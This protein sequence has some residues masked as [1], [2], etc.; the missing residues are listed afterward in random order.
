MSIFKKPRHSGNIVSGRRPPHGKIVGVSTK[1]N[2]GYA[3][4]IVNR[5]SSTTEQ[6]AFDTD[7]FGLNAASY[8]RPKLTRRQ[9]EFDLSTVIMVTGTSLGTLFIAALLCAASA[10]MIYDIFPPLRWVLFPALL[11]VFCAFCCTR[12]AIRRCKALNTGIAVK[13]SS[14]VI[15]TLICGGAFYA[16][17]VAFGFMSLIS[18]SDYYLDYLPFELQELVF[19]V[20]MG[21]IRLFTTCQQA[22]FAIIPAFGSILA[23]LPAKK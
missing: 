6:Y 18:M 21:F 16:F 7:E 10:E 13:I 17:G 15:I 22:T 9:H 12:A 4:T 5:P 2:A 1:N 19:D 3:G 20:D 11:T 23:W 8:N 14:T